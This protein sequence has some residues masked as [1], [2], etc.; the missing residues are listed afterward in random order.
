[1]NLR[2]VKWLSLRP[3]WTP[4][5]IALGLIGFYVWWPLGAAV[6]AYIVIGAAVWKKKPDIETPYAD[7]PRIEVT[8][9]EDALRLTGRYTAPSGWWS[10][11]FPA[12]L[13][14]LWLPLTLVTCS[15]ATN[16][17]YSKGTSQE[18]LGSPLLVG[19]IFFVM[20]VLGEI[21]GPRR[22]LNVTIGRDSIVISG[23]RYMRR[24]GLNQFAIEEHEKTRGEAVVAARGHGSGR[25]YRDAMQVVMRYGEKRVPVA[26]FRRQDVRK[27]E[28]L[29]VRLQGLNAKLDELLAPQAQGVAAPA[30]PGAKDEFGPA[31][32]IR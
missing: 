8:E 21:F 7:W 18:F 28:A 29:L 25:I 13:V 6:L 9:A 30:M 20:A 2:E 11:G 22:K 5:P 19:F 10:E 12:L 4:L 27:A 17:N 26:A 31:R 14:V 3:G 24:E 16:G 15:L 1:M 32:P 23:T